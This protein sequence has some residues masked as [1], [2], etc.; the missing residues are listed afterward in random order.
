ME[1]ILFVEIEPPAVEGLDA[2]EYV[3]LGAG[4]RV[5]ARDAASLTAA[6]GHATD[7]AAAARAAVAHPGGG[8]ARLRAALDGTAEGAARVARV[9]QAGQVLLSSPVQGR[10]GDPVRDLGEHRLPDL[11]PVERL[12]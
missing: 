2:L 3:V 9:A 5:A 7:A 1:T 10:L 8:R 11:A 12:F 4:G 6:F